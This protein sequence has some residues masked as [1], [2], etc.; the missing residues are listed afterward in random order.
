MNYLSSVELYYSLS[1]M[2]RG[3]EINISNDDYKHSIKVMRHSVADEIYVTNG[4]G[5]IFLSV[6]KEIKKDFLN[7]SVKKVIVYENDFS[8]IFFCIPKLKSSDR[9]EFALEK[10]TEL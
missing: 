2:I 10:C 1:E 4:K 8:N 6:I 3:N 7:T 9:F 5:K